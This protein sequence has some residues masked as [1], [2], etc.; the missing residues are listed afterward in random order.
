MFNLQMK[1]SGLRCVEQ[2]LRI[3]EQTTFRNV[4]QLGRAD[5]RMGWAKEMLDQMQRNWGEDLLNSNPRLIKHN[6]IVMCN[7]GRP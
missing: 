5:L 2:Q 3:V 4:M 1:V 6:F 7:Q